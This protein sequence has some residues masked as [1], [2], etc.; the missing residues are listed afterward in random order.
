[1]N[2]LTLIERAAV[3]KAVAA[4]NKGILPGSYTGSVTVKVDYIL[5]KSQDYDVAPTVNLLSKAV[6]AKALTKVNEATRNAFLAVLVEVATDVLGK[7]GEVADEVQDANVL[8]K[9]AELEA[10]AIARLPRQ[11][12]SGT[13]KVKA[14]VAVVATENNSLLALAA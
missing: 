8:A 1:M 10:K 6:L 12:R 9:I 2:T 14:S 7:G 11:P 13:T 3:A 5:Q 4:D